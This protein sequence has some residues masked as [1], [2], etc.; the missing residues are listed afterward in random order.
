MDFIIEIIFRAFFVEIV[1]LHTRYFFFIIIGK[2]IHQLLAW[3]E[4]E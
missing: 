2:K 4:Y 1:G 3:K